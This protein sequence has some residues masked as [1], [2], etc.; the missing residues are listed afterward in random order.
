MKLLLMVPFKN[1]PPP[2]PIKCYILFRDPV[3]ELVTTARL[4]RRK[5]HCEAVPTLA[6]Q[7]HSKKLTLYIKPANR[8]K[9]ILNVW[10]NF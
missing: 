7:V 6:L 3:G 9:Y 5:L 8:L 4:R 1:H 2:R 10:Y